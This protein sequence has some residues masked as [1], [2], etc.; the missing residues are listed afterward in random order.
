MEDKKDPFAF[1][2]VDDE[3][4]QTGLTI[5]DYF[6]AKALQGMVSRG[7]ISRSHP[8]KAKMLIDNRADIA[9]QYA[10]AMMKVR[11]ERIEKKNDSENK[12]TKKQEL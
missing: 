5:T 10:D 12:Q 9:Y 11:R 8:L 4:L 3:Y 6:A 7:D 1:P 2:C